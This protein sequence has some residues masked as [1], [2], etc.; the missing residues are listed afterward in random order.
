MKKALISTIEPVL[1]GFR[2]AQIV[3]E[4]NVFEV[5]PELFWVDCADDVTAD[6]FYYDP[7][8]S[9]MLIN[10]VKAERDAWLAQVFA[11]APVA[12]PVSA[13]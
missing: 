11:P 10:T 7:A 8:T 4:A 3:D 6:N 1:S 12:I 13:M 2:V 5:S 9:S